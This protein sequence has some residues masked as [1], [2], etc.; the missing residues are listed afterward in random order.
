[1]LSISEFFMSIATRGFVKK[2]LDGEQLWKVLSIPHEGE[3]LVFRPDQLV[4]EFLYPYGPDSKFTP[5]DLPPLLFVALPHITDDHDAL[6]E[7]LAPIIRARPRGSLADHYAFLFGWL[8]DRMEKD[9]WIERSGASLTFLPPLRDMYP[10]AKFIHV[11][12]DGRDVAMSMVRHAPTRLYAHAWHTAGKI[13]INPLKRPFLMGETPIVPM[14]EQAALKVL[15]ME[16]KLHTPLPPK[17]TGAF[18]SAMIE[19][20]LKNLEGLGPDRLMSMRYEDLV[21]DPRAELSRFIN[22]LGPDLADDAWL[23]AASAIPR[24]RDPAWKDLPADDLAALERAV[25]P[26]MTLLGYDMP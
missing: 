22:F 3:K 7:E 20:G 8:R 6:Y 19:V 10:D 14:F 23:E 26:G 15:G 5:E 25:A 4:D 17:D 1:M 18:W 11:Y 13:G 16:K 12:R 21:A 9:L 2:T 24:Y